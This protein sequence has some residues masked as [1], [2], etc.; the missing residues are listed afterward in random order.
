M[1][2]VAVPQK[3]SGS[4]REALQAYAAAQPDDPRPGITAALAH[5]T[6][7]SSNGRHADQ[8]EAGDG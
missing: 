6:P 1:I 7:P 4:A 2:E 3:L 5:L 8:S